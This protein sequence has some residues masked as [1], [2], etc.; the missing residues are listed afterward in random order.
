[1]K[2]SNSYFYTLRE[3]VK[4]EDTTSGNL[5]VRAGYIKKTSSGVYMF[6]PLGLRVLKNIENIV[7]QEMNNVGA[8]E[9]LMPAL[10][11][12]DYYLTSGRREIIGSSMFSLK[13]RFSKSFVLGPTHEELFA[14]AASMKIHSYKDLPFNLYQFQDKFRDEPR[15]RF[16]LIRVREFIMKDAYSFDADLTGLDTSYKK[17]FSAYVAA[18]DRMQLD[19]RV[20]T[21]DTGIMGGLLSEEFQAITD[22][23]EDVLVLCENC[24]FA[25][26]LEIAECSQ[27]ISVVSDIVLPKELIHTPNVKS[28]SE[29]ADFLHIDAGKFVKTLIYKVDNAFYACLVQGTDELNE[30]KLRKHLQAV[31]VNLAS[32][33]E[34]LELV[35][36][37]VGFVG[38]INLT[39][40]II[41][42]QKVKT[43]INFIIGANQK[44]YHFINVNLSDFSQATFVDIVNVKNGDICPACGGNL[45]FKKGI[46]IGNTF[47]LGNKYSKAMN[48]QYLD[49]NNQLQDVIM[50]SYGIGIGRCMA[51]LVEQNN[52]DN[53]LIWPNELAP[54]RACIILISNKDPLQVNCANRI[55]DECMTNG[56]E[57][58]LDDRDERPGIKFKDSDL[59]GIPTRIVVGRDAGDGFV[60]IKNR[61]SYESQ[62]IAIDQ[63]IDALLHN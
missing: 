8:Q 34:V 3:H 20:V 13:D 9:S 61:T 2:L 38:P 18:F 12:E 32:A 44:D 37:E 35:D 24:D 26:N 49:C 1:M 52:D 39:I 6:L 60:E 36:V 28:I 22:V 56:I 25:A 33:Q 58:I 54:Y 45:V 62:K 7:R 57:V 55:Y 4:D 40:P 17:M 21:A 46:E 14:L 23:G 41:A 15:P 11:S 19:Y 51:A 53:G 16:G 48:L 63:V 29:V 27:S 47:K 10:I 31:E 5:L 59:I 43:M 42:D 50:G 30:P